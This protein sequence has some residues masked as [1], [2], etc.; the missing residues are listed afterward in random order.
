M[1]SK[2]YSDTLQAIYKADSHKLVASVP[3]SQHLLNFISYLD[4]DL[5]HMKVRIEQK[6][7]CIDVDDLYQ[8]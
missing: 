6:Y 8:Y 3:V 5:D 1:T 7:T 2:I 4:L